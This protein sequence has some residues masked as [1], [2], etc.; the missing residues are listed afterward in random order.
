MGVRNWSTTV[1]KGMSMFV[2]ELDFER[3]PGKTDINNHSFHF[4]GT[5]AY[6][7]TFVFLMGIVGM[8]FLTSVA[9]GETKEISMNSK[10]Y[11]Y[12][13]IAELVFYLEEL[14][15]RCS[16]RLPKALHKRLPKFCRERMEK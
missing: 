11:S 2:G 1:T 10:M 14:G 9:I 12:R 4:Y 6:F 8:N 16:K 13:S 3:I 15:Q 5:H 7:F